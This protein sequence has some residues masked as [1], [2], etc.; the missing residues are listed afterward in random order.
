MCVCALCRPTDD[1]Q[2]FWSDQEHSD[3]EIECD[4]FDSDHEDPS[5][6]E[7]DCD[8][9]R[10]S[11]WVVFPFS[12]MQPDDMCCKLNKLIQK[13]TIPKEG[14]FYKHVLNVTSMF[15]DPQNYV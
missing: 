13:G 5:E 9:D 12:I 1:L 2:D 8:N 14:I 4:L 15:L 7:D 10:D 6:L 3:P 11:D